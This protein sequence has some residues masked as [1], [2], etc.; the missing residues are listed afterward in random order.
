MNSLF[1]KIEKVIPDDL[2]SFQ[3]HYKETLNSKVK[4]INTVVNYI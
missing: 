3:Y 2:K 4:L 1:D